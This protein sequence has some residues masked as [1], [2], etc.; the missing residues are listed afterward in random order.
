M[1]ITL[2]IYLL[3]TNFRIK[4]VTTEIQSLQTGNTAESGWDTSGKLI[5]L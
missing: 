5:V 2:I 1:I 4:L 3:K